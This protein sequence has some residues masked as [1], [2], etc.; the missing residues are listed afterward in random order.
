MS[1]KKQNRHELLS[2]SDMDPDYRREPKTEFFCALCQRDIKNKNTACGIHVVE[3]GNSICHPGDSHLYEGD[4]GDCGIY[5]VG[6]ECAKKVNKEYR[7][8]LD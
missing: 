1:N 6:P 5:Y 7:L 3:G 4:S 2:V 8:S